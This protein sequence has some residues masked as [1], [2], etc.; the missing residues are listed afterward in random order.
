MKTARGDALRRLCARYGIA[1]DY[2]DVWGERHDVLARLAGRAAARC[3]RRA[4]RR[5]RSRPPKRRRARAPGERPL[6][7]VRGAWPR[8]PH[9]SSRRAAP[10]ASGSRISSGAWST[11]AAPSTRAP[12]RPPRCTRRARARSTATATRAT[13]CTSRSPLPAGLPPAEP[14]RHAR[15]DAASSARPAHAISRP[16][17]PRGGRVCGASTLQLYGLRSPRN[18]G[19]GDFTDLAAFVG[20]GRA[21]RRAAWSASIRC[22]RCS[23]TTRRTR[24]RTA[25]RRARNLNVLY[26]DVEA[27]PDFRDAQPARERGALAPPSRPGWPRCA[28]R[29]WSITRASRPPSTRCWRCSIAHFLRAARPTPRCRPSRDFRARGGEAAAAARR[30]SRRCRRTSTS[31]DPAGLGLARL[32]R[33]LPRSG[34][35]E[36]G[37]TSRRRTPSASATSNTCNGRRRASSKRRAAQ[38]A[39]AGHADRPVPGPGGV[40]RPRRLGHLAPPAPASRSTRSVGAPPDVF[41][42]NGQDWGLPPLRP[43]RLRDSRLRRLHRGAA[44]QHARRRRDPHRPR[45][46]ADAAV[47]DSRRRHAAR[48]RLRALPARGAVRDPRAGEPAPPLPGDRRGPGHRARRDARGDAPLR[49][50][51]VP[52]AVLR[53]RS[54]MAPSAPPADYPRDAVVAVST[55]DLRHAGGLV[56]A[57]T[58]CDSAPSSACSPNDAAFEQQVRERAQERVACCRGGAAPATC[59]RGTRRRRERRQPG[60]GRRRRRPCLPGR[61]A[62]EHR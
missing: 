6:P 26:I 10:A 31:A 30:C 2:H 45:D 15:R 22:M 58:T 54:A 50:A 23:R 27:V 9:R 47:L 44:R 20:A 60:R 61:G 40:G 16:R 42:P 57:C 11:K 46:D 33:G 3:R 59:R 1:T 32:A 14:R 17:W 38:C 53:A 48:R 21:R 34:V 55:H 36:V 7:P 5:G 4:A 28:R 29:R 12:S 8:A 19:I 56:G 18:W 49:R 41:N 37:R 24:A 43:D 51:V 52:A 35:G 39:R 13:A 25:P 62:V